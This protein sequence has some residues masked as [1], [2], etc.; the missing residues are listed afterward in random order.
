MGRAIVL[1]CADWWLWTPADGSEPEPQSGAEWTP[2]NT[3]WAPG[4]T[5]PNTHKHWYTHAHTSRTHAHATQDGVSGTQYVHPAAAHCFPSLLCDRSCALLSPLVCSRARWH[6]ARVFLCCVVCR[7]PPLRTPS[8]MSHPSWPCYAI[9]VGKSCCRRTPRSRCCQR[10]RCVAQRVGGGAGGDAPDECHRCDHHNHNY[11][12][13]G[14]STAGIRRGCS[15]H[16]HPSFQRGHVYRRGCGRA[17]TWSR[18]GGVGKRSHLR[19]YL[20]HWQAERIRPIGG[21]GQ[22]VGARRLL[23]RR[24]AAWTW[25]SARQCAPLNNN[26]ILAQWR[27]N[28]R[29]RERDGVAACRQRGLGHWWWLST[30]SRSDDGVHSGWSVVRR[31]LLPHWPCLLLRHAPA[32][33]QALRGVVLQLLHE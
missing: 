3:T 22:R 18:Q 2:R 25:H 16:A 14:R 24:Q 4:V 29:A 26:R 5:P 11:V 8:S 7:C 15:N 10:V 20:A 1:A 23:G 33:M 19:R 6:A 32:P 12:A 21:R 27:S 28:R 30:R 9:A 13:C 17:A 31:V